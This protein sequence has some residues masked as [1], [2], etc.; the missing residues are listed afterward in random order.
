[1]TVSL[2][3][4]FQPVFELGQFKMH[5]SPLREEVAT[6]RHKR[7]EY[8]ASGNFADITQPNKASKYHGMGVSCELKNCS[9]L[10]SMT[11]NAVSTSA[12]VKP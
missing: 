2:L 7:R 3:L 5:S 9:N 8:S 1:M 6:K 11:F 10:L 4:A 12:Y